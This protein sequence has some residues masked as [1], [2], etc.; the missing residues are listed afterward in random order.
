MLGGPKYV[1]MNQIYN[2]YKQKTKIRK[3]KEKNMKLEFGK[4]GGAFVPEKVQLA[5]KELEE[6]FEDAIKDQAFIDEYKFYLKEYVGRPSLLY[7]AKNLTEQIGGA[8][9]YLKR[10]DL[11]HTGSHKINNCLGQI[12]LAKRMGKKKIIAETGAGQHGVAAATA[13]ALFNME[14]EV[15]QGEVDMKRQRLNVFK[16]ET[17]N[18]K[19]TPVT[20]GTKTLNDAVD[21]AIENWVERIE[22]TFYLI[23]SVVGPNPYPRIVEFF[24]K[25]IGEEAKEQILKLEG[26]LPDYCVACVG[27]G[28]NAI[29]LFNSFL[30]E[31]VVQLIGV[32]AAGLGIDTKY[33]AAALTKGREGIIHGMNTKV[34][35][36]KENNILPAYSISAGLDYPGVGPVHAYLQNIKR[37]NYAFVTDEEAVN[38]FMLLSKTEGIIPAIESSHAIS[39]AVNL[40]KTLDKSKVIIINLSG[41]GDKDIEIIEEFLNNKKNKANG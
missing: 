30:S 13:A 10:E 25:I 24:Q 4:F 34:L 35:M 27:G 15:F 38:A 6:A 41:R 33:H 1:S 26:R 32:E 31:D 5:L 9:I 18:A 3:L 7:Y 28:S 19:V 22:D 21:V 29:G 23:G 14:C 37:C 17:L 36:D 40:A 12:L 8:K 16:M 20:V 11:N 2:Y 39:Y